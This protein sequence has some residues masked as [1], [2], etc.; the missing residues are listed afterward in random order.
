M[1]AGIGSLKSSK[2]E[3]G[4]A[5]FAASPAGSFDAHRNPRT[6]QQLKTSKVTAAFVAAT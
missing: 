5:A 4:A 2:L 1:C 6:I 3:N